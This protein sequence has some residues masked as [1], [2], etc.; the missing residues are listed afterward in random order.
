[1]KTIF[2]EIKDNGK[3]GVYNSKNEEIIPTIAFNI[4]KL[5]KD[6]YFEVKLDEDENSVCLFN[7]NGKQITEAKFSNVSEIVNN[8][9]IMLKKEGNGYSRNAFY[10]IYDLENPNNRINNLQSY[11]HIIVMNPS[12]KKH[13]LL[14]KIHDRRSGNAVI[15]YLGN[16]VIPFG[17]YNTILNYGEG[18]YSVRIEGMDSGYADKNGNLVIKPIFKDAGKFEN[19]IAK[20]TLKEKT[21]YIDKNGNCVIDCPTEKWLD[22][23]KISNFKI[24][25]TLYSQLIKQGLQESNQEEYLTSIETFSQAM[26]E[27]P[28]DYEAYYNRGLSYLMLNQL[29]KAEED[30]NKSIKY[31]ST[32]SNSYYLRGNIYQR[33]GDF[34]SAISDFEKAIKLNPNNPDSY[35]K[36]AIL[37]GKRGNRQKSCE[38]MKRACE[39]GSYDACSG[40]SRFCE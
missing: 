31:N 11:N 19:G 26:E 4:R 14:F 32:F 7:N 8:Y 35:M 21:F 25:N 38:Y 18:M 39:L 5:H 12:E 13:E 2:F 6:K 3:R 28:L 33:R 20:V 36:C 10:K 29:D 34:Y 16:L 23:H 22:Y 40:Y 30:F 24:N 37:Y 9:A 1:M 15:D 27:F 17:K